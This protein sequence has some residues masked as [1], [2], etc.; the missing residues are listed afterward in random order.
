MGIFCCSPIWKNI[1]LNVVKASYEWQTLSPAWSILTVCLFPP[2]VLVEGHKD[3]QGMFLR[4]ERQDLNTG[5]QRQV[6]EQSTSYTWKLF[7]PFR[8]WI[9]LSWLMTP[10]IKLTTFGY[11]I[12]KSLLKYYLNGKFGSCIHPFKN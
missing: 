8:S 2:Y 12:E 11:R 3:Q 9:C 5:T 7:F 1:C 4:R 6:Q 10:S